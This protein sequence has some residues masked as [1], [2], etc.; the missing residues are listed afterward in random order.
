MNRV[1]DE[2]LWRGLV[3]DST[4]REALSAHL[5]AGPVTSYVGFDPT[6]P[7]LHIGHLVQLMVVRA[8]HVGGHH[9]LLLVGGSTGLIGDPKQAGERV[10]N[11]K[12]VVAGW[13]ERLREQMSRF[14][15]LDGPNPVRFVNNYDWT[16][17]LSTLDFLRDVGK[18][19]SINRMLDRDVV[20]RRLDSGISYTEF[21][22][23][24]LQSLDYHELYKRHGCTLQTGAQDQWGNITAGIDYIRRT[25]RAGVHG[26]VT[27]LL[28]KADGTKYGKTE[29]GT[30]WLDAELTSPY[31]FHQYFLNA[32]D[33]KVVEYLKVFSPRSREEIEDLARQ[34]AEEAWQRAAQRALADDITDLVHGE[35]ERKAAEAAAAALFGRSELAELPEGT[36]A[37]VAGEV[38]GGELAA[39]AE[40]PLVVDALLAA[41]VVDSKG[42]ARR[43][44]AEG[45]AY[46]NNQKVSDAEARLQDSDL[47]H[48][49][50]AVVRRG[51]KTV[52]MVRVRR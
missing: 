9:P 49:R 7:S 13:V 20:A 46:L 22:Y 34:T 43:A 25:E 17:E 37:Q 41:G 3:A 33:A 2:L 16:A 4:D 51:K 50:Y 10:M 42:A 6:A 1:L 15:E 47:L 12:E 26:L 48:G 39:G 44:I 28:T 31:A 11:G 24:L 29:S 30:I 45:G 14:V 5:D 27:P 18:H 35:A 38:G 8:L 23:V 36:L 32:E 40:L 52:G 19:F 21:S